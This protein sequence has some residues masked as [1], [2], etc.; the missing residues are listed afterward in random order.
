MPLD[1]SFLWGAK[2]NQTERLAP[3]LCGWERAEY[4][5]SPWTG[6]TVFIT[7]IIQGKIS[8]LTCYFSEINW[9]T[10]LMWINVTLNVIIKSHVS[11]N[12]CEPRGDMFLLPFCPFSVFFFRSEDPSVKNSH[13]PCL[14]PGIAQHFERNGV[15]VFIDPWCPVPSPDAKVTMLAASPNRINRCCDSRGFHKKKTTQRQ[16]IFP[17][18]PCFRFPA[19]GGRIQ[20]GHHLSLLT[21]MTTCT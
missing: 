15:M 8:Y 6:S 9:T 19:V 2:F 18:E 20:G 7:D 4:I 13:F 10:R 17:Q 5:G 3:E 12:Y 16:S 14:V 21:V 11:L 1:I